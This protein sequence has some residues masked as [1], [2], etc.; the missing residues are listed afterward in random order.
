MEPAMPLDIALGK[1]FPD[2]GVT[3]EQLLS[4]I[5]KGELAC[6]KIGRGYYVTASDIKQW[7]MKC[8]EKGS[9]PD[10]ASRTAKS[11]D[12]DGSLSMDERKS[13]LAAAL[14]ITKR[15]KKSSVNISLK[16]KPSTLAPGTPLRLVS[17]T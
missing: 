5:R 10:C 8:R 17:Q 9:R 15:L 3:K 6:E 14:A 12:S 11:V 1:F 4:A 13:T 16:R 7:R 2:G